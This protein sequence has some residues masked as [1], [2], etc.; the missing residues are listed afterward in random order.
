[1][2]DEEEVE[3]VLPSEKIAVTN[4]NPRTTIIYSQP[5]MGK[6]TLIAEL[7]DCLLIDLESG[8]DFVEALKVKVS[9]LKE[10]YKVGEQIK[11]KG[12][13]YKYVAI[14]TITALEQW[15][16][17]TAKSMYMNTPMGKNF[18]GESVLTLPNGA[19]YLYLR[20]AF[21]KWLD[22]CGTLAEHIILVGHL[23]DKMINK[24]GK[25]VAA[26]DLALTGQIRTITCA[27]ADAVGFLYRDKDELR[28]NFQAKE[29]LVCGSRCEHLKG[30]D[31]VFAWDKIY[32]D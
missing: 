17:E 32:I 29:E 9:S 28:I 13:P 4:R 7:P 31:F 27:N 14:D 18:K 15:C 19:G 25:E 22:Y 20:L 1:M 8:S 10:L 11:A 21:K 26:K 12:K 6:T 30:Q 23:K 3:I 16:E 24:D 2:S 5:K